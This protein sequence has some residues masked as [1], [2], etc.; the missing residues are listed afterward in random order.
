MLTRHSCDEGGILLYQVVRLRDPK[1]F[2][3]RRPDGEGEWVGNLEGVRRVLYRLPE[4]L[5]ADTVACCE[6]ERDADSLCALG[7][8]ATCNPMGARKWRPEYSEFL[9]GKRVPIFQD[10]DED[11]RAHARQVATNLLGVALEVRVVTVPTG[12]DITD[13]I[14]SG[15]TRDDVMALAR[16]TPIFG[17]ALPGALE[18]VSTEPTSYVDEPRLQE[19]GRPAAY[20]RANSGGCP[21][22]L[23]FLYNDAGNAARLIAV[24]G[25]D[26]RY[27]YAFRKAC[28]TTASKTWTPS[29]S[30]TSSTLLSSPA[31]KP[32]SA[33]PTNPASS[34]ACAVSPNH[35]GHP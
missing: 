1:D 20:V 27:C 10:N 3:Q 19:A 15:A 11:G 28:A 33:R 32:P 7:V 16:Q 8:T 34:K 25:Q 13:Y 12:K 6:G 14:A 2:R 30:N 17:G 29:T 23:E 22:L 35:D 24:H 21:D 5:K 18:H 9:R 4:V 26:L 31:D